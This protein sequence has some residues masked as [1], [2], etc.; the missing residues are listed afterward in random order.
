MKT[1]I[2]LATKVAAALLA[3]A[4]SNIRGIA[5]DA[6]RFGQRPKPSAEMKVRQAVEASGKDLATSA[7][8]LQEALEEDPSYYRA[9]LNLGLIRQAQNLKKEAVSELEVA[10]EMKN[11]YDVKDAGIFAELGFAYHRA[12]MY[13][14]AQKAF[15]DGVANITKLTPQEQEKLLQ[16]GVAFYLEY[17]NPQAATILYETAKGGLNPALR[18]TM[19][20]FLK[21][22]IE[23]LTRND[24][25]GGWVSYGREKLTVTGSEWG[26]QLFRKVDGSPGVPKAGEKITPLGGAVNIR[27]DRRRTENK[28]TQLA[29]AVGYARPGEV[30]TVVS[31]PFGVELDRDLAGWKAWWVQVKRDK[32]P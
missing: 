26:A 27:M 13:E 30:F 5:A 23:R 31:E 10:N 32:A 14:Q 17:Q 6:D 18:A 21:Q 11:A 29:L 20:T 24:V 28:E 1:F 9:Q 7:K 15:A 22:G 25:D 12:D 16:R 4:S 3:L 19:D 2:S 8:L